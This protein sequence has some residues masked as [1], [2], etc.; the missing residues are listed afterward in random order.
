MTWG[1]GSGFLTTSL[2]IFFVAGLFF[3]WF[4]CILVWGVVFFNSSSL[5][6]IPKRCSHC[7]P[8]LLQPLPIHPPTFKP[9][10]MSNSG[11][12]IRLAHLPYNSS[13]SSWNPS[14][15]LALLSHLLI[16]FVYE[17]CNSMYVCV[18][19]LKPTLSKPCYKLSQSYCI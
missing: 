6:A 16:N 15:T 14:L 13:L 7:K 8:R 19:F 18:S 3:V 11:S 12:I 1:H 9:L 2:P 5:L 17:I 4:G 10:I